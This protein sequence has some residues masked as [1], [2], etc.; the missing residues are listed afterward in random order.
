MNAVTFRNLTEVTRTF[1]RD[2]EYLLA[3]LTRNSLA[4]LQ[5]IVRLGIEHFNDGLVQ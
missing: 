5:P 2:D 4:D 1:R 3:H